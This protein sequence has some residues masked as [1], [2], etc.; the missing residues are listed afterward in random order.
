MENG[1]L[2]EAFIDSLGNGRTL[3][4]RINLKYL[5]TKHLFF[6]LFAHDAFNDHRCIRGDDVNAVVGGNERKTKK[7]NQ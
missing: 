5:S 7:T 3:G 2:K 6:N 1:E 4:Y